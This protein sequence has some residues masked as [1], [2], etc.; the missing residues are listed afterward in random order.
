MIDMTIKAFS[1]RKKIKKKRK[2]NGI[3]DQIEL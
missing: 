2:C 3:D 1:K